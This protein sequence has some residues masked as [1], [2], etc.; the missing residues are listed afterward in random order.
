MADIQ[1]QERARNIG[2]DY[3]RIPDRKHVIAAQIA[4]SQ[5]GPPIKVNFGRARRLR[6]PHGRATLH[7]Q[8]RPV[9]HAGNDDVRAGTA[10]G[11][12]CAERALAPW[13]PDSCFCVGG[14]RSCIGRRRR[15][16][17]IGSEQVM[18]TVCDP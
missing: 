5:K 6:H 8:L 1:P 16:I 12:H 15:F 17:H 7:P 13:L 14:R 10:H 11:E 3:L 2:D 9:G 18:L 4:R